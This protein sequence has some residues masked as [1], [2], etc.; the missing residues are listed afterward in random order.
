MSGDSSFDSDSITNSE[1]NQWRWLSFP[2]TR[3]SLNP[4]TGFQIPPMAPSLPLDIGGYLETGVL[5][6]ANVVNIRVLSAPGFA[7]NEGLSTSRSTTWYPYQITFEATFPC[8][9]RVSGCDFFLDT[10]STVIHIMRV[11]SPS[12]ADLCLSGKAIASGSIR[13]DETNQVIL[14]S[15]SRYHYALR[16][17]GLSG[18]KLTAFELAPKPVV[19]E[20]SWSLK[21]SSGPDPTALGITSGFATAGEGRALAIARA[22][23][24]FSQ[25]VAS[26]LA[27][28][29]AVMDGYLRR[30]PLPSVWGITGIPTCGV[31][32]QQ[33]RRAYYAAWAF[34]IQDVMNAMPDNPAYPYPQMGVGK[35][36]MWQDGEATSPATCSWESLLGYQWLS[37]L[38]P[39]TA[40]QAYEGLMSRVDASGKL[41]GESLPSRKAQT[42]WLLHKNSP[43]RARLG[44][45][46]P[47]LRRYL[48]W[49]ELNPRWIYKA[50]DYP[51]EKDIEFVVSWLVDVDYAI[52][53]ANELELPDEARLWQRRVGPMMDNLRT[54][55]FSD[56]KYLHQFR[57]TARD[58]YYFADR[59]QDDPIYIASALALKELPSDMLDRLKSFFLGIHDPGKPNDG[60]PY[61]KYPDNNLIACGLANY[62]LGETRPFV[63]ALLR[64]AIRV[65]EFGECIDPGPVVG[66]TRPSLFTALNIIEF[67]WMLNNVRYESG[68]PTAFEFPPCSV[69][70]PAA[71]QAHPGA[72]AAAATRWSP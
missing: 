37:F 60:F 66:G 67:T 9:T 22:R 11:F 30:V 13:W 50:H 64:D 6:L 35:P 71:R 43:D 23:N 19:I 27:N 55:F 8:G 72:G 16:F 36:S 56:P 42:A 10:N 3:F 15:D 29:K 20:R 54:W 39:E 68:A 33:H 18:E 28:T 40:W 17:V 38:L 41:G 1:T 2:G 48:L 25:P 70:K 45:I 12:K 49:R 69:W 51:D 24:A 59:K 63:E 62:G 26:S 21:I 65:G 32:P 44:R 47:A 7:T 52:H 5:R 34:L 46:Y 53:I 14:V 31:T 58:A 4:A 61:T 57:F